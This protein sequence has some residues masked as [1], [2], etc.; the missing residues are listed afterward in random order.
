MLKYRATSLYTR[1]KSHVV[2]GNNKHNTEY[3]IAY[4]DFGEWA[5]Q[6]K[7]ASERGSIVDATY[8]CLTNVEYGYVKARCFQWA[9]LR[10][11]DS[12]DQT[13]CKLGIYAKVTNCERT[14][15]KIYLVRN[16]TS[17]VYNAAD[18][19]G[20]AVNR[21]FYCLDKRVEIPEEKLDEDALKP[22]SS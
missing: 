19:E 12:V 3:S 14:D 11:L 13:V 8:Y 2:L 17:R 15:L 10:W 21:F 4:A 9:N 6:M 22:S 16:P 7:K 20:M 18:T 1:D 5:K